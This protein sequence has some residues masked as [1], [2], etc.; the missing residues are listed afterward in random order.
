MEK[1]QMDVLENVRNT[2]VKNMKIN[3]KKKKKLK[4]RQ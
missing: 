4:I 2:E 3:L 1:R